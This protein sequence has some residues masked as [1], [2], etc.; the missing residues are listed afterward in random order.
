MSTMAIT[1]HSTR[2]GDVEVGEDAVVE[3]PRGLVGLGGTRFALLATSADSPFAWLHSLEDPDLALPVTRP[4]DFFADYEI[5]MSDEDSAVLGIA[6]AAQAEVWVTVR[7]AERLEEF[8]ANLRAP[9]VVAGGRAVQVINEIADAPV[10]A[11]LF[12]AS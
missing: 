1:V 10:R 2:F 5:S 12:A 8:T 7:A 11:S 4:W 6:D 3:F 9:I